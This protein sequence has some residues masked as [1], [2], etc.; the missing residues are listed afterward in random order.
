MLDS[1]AQRL[2]ALNHQFYQTF[3]VQFSET[4]Q[5]IQPGVRQ[6]VDENRLF[7]DVLDLGCG[8]AGLARVLH[9][10][11]F[12]G[13]YT[14][15]D[16]SVG[17]LEAAQRDLPPDFPAR[18]AVADLAAPGWAND[19]PAEGFDC[20]CAFAVLH[21]LPGTK[22]RGALLD[23]VRRLLKPGGV[24]LLSNWQFLNSPR[25]TARLQPWESAG[26]QEGDLDPGDYLL[27]W[28]SGGSG[29]RY[30]HHF[31]PEELAGLAQ[32]HGFEVLETFHADGEAGR[33]GVYGVWKPV[34][35]PG[36]SS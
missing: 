28:R 17:L 16:F 8:N 22:I 24:F 12:T 34:L 6:L 18:F 11:G 10:R 27:D 4:R 14:G 31:S 29:L 20:V 30:V 32:Q 9:S 25:L 7:G 35:F 3:A 13:S 23:G 19:L 15:V 1:T 5:R 26:L 2:L 33:L 21:H 36:G